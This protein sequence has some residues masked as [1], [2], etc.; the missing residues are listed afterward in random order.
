MYISF[1]P[2]GL[3]SNGSKYGHALIVVSMTVR[4]LHLHILPNSNQVLI[5][6]CILTVGTDDRPIA[7]RGRVKL[8]PSHCYPVIGPLLP[9]THPLMTS[10]NRSKDVKETEDGSRWLTILESC[11]PTD[12]GPEVD[13]LLDELSLD[14]GGD[15]KRRRHNLIILQHNT[16]LRPGTID[17]AW[18]DACNLFG[19][20][21]I[22]WNPAMFKNR[23]IYHGLVFATLLATGAP[24][25]T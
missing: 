7:Y 2:T 6:Q 9:S 18:D 8:L 5:G 14:G 15:N 19:C 20:V 3:R 25:S 23:L 12:N 11:L 22:S 24:S 13:A 4:I 1:I 10:D 21:C 16:Y 17:I